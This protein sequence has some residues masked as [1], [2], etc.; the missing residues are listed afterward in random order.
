M[1]LRN[2]AAVNVWGDG[3]HVTGKS[4][5]KGGTAPTGIVVRDAYVSNS[6]RQGIAVAG[7]DGC[8]SNAPSYA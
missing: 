2:I 8:W 4:F 3:V 5:D 1:E 6:G 7:V